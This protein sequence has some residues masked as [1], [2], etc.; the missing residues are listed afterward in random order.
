MSSNRGKKGNRGGRARLNR[1]R[2]TQQEKRMVVPKSL[3]V[4]PDS[5]VVQLHYRET[6]RLNG[7]AT[8]AKR[9]NT[10]AAFDVDPALGGLAMN[11]FNTWSTFYSFNKV[12]SYKVDMDI[13]NVEPYPMNL[14]FVHTNIDPGTSPASYP[15]WSTN[16]YG[17]KKMIGAGNGSGNYHYQRTHSIKQIVGDQLSRTSE[18]Y[19]GSSSA[20]PADVTY[21]G[22]MSE[23]IIAA[24]P[25]GI[26]YN[27]VLTLTVKFFDRKNLDDV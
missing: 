7:F 12:L 1:E 17:S 13:C 20:N 2:R 26:M 22:I 3:A 16:A 24:A 9:W 8:V 19:V 10:N 18:R 11:G 25:G 5:I 21:F 14:Y 4:A 27:L 23:D 15:V 6:S